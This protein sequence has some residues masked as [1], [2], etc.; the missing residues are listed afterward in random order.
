MVQS[1]LSAK[2]RNVP[3]PSLAES[4]AWL[5]WRRGFL[6]LSDLDGRSRALPLFEFSGAALL[7]SRARPQGLCPR[8][9]ARGQAPLDPGRGLPLGIAHPALLYAFFILERSF[10]M[11]LISTFYDHILDISTQRSILKTVA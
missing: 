1:A 11:P 7:R 5:L 9:P 6:P 2:L 4:T 8:T 10:S 3:F